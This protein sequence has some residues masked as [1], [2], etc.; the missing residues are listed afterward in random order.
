MNFQVDENLLQVP[1]ETLPQPNLRYDDNFPKTP[2]RGYWNLRGNGQNTVVKFRRATQ[3]LKNFHVLAM[4]GSL[5]GFEVETA[6]DAMLVQLRAHG[7]KIEEEG[8]TAEEAEIMLP[9]A[10]E[11]ESL[12]EGYQLNPRGYLRRFLNGPPDAVTRKPKQPHDCTLILIPEKDYHNYATAKRIADFAGRHVLFA[13]GSKL[14]NFRKEDFDQQYMSNLA[15]K[16]NMK[17]GGENHHLDTTGLSNVLSAKIRRDTIVLGADIGHTG[18]GGRLGNPSVACV[19]G[20]VSQSFMKYPGSMRLQAG[21]QEVS[22]AY[23][24]HD[25]F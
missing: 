11:L 21:G 17:F 15:L 10:I 4:P 8:N 19:V 5:A 3:E 16:I 20:S 13:I 14:F 12:R 1:A 23:G 18:A 7:I 2:L 6:R 22:F 24:V 9:E 25:L